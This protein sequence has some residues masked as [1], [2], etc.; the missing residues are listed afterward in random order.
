MRYFAV[1]LCAL[2]LSAAQQAPFT[3][4][5]ALSAAF[6]SELTAAPVGGMVAWV[7]NV[8]GVRNI[9]IAGPPDY[10]ARSITAYQA[11]DGQEIQ[12]LAWA[13]DASAIAYVR[14]GP[15]NPT[16]NPA[17]PSRDVWVISLN[18]G[19]PRKISDGSSPS[20]APKGNRIAYLR[21]GQ[22][23]LAPAD[24]SAPPAQAFHDSGR[25][26]K[27]VWSPDGSRFA[28]SSIRGDHSF[29]GVFDL[30]SGRVRFLNPSTANDGDP[31]WAPDGRSVAFIRIPSTG[32]R[33]PRQAM[34]TGE[35]WSIHIA[36]PETGEGREIWRAREG[37]GSVFRQVTAGSQLLWSADGRIAFPWE[38][39][40]WTHLYSVSAAG[41]D[42]ALLTPGG[43]EVE[44]VALAPGGR[45]LVFSSNQSDLDR[46][47][48]WRVAISGGAPAAVTS[49]SGIECLPAVASDGA[50][51]FMRSNARRPVHAAILIGS[52]TAREL[53][54][55]SI[56]ADFPERN[57]VEPQAVTF[58]SADGLTL[59]A[60]LFLPP[61]KTAGRAPAV[62]FFH[63]GPRRQMMLGWHPMRYYFNAYALNQ[64]LANSGYIVLSVNFRSGIG[65]GM[66]FREAEGYGAS[67][68]SDY[69]DVRAAATYLRTRADVDP[70]RVGAWG[71][72]YGGFLTAMALARNSDLFRAGVDF[73][74]VHNWATELNIPPTEPDYKIAFDSSP[75]AFV[76]TWRSPALLIHGDD[77]PDVQF[78]QTV[79]LASALR[80]QGVAVQELILPNESHEFL[81]HSSWVRTYKAAIEFLNKSLR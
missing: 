60:Q 21:S 61:S 22:I 59:H 80:K 52:S 12:N 62:V 78:N 2:S 6:P 75:M 44:D 72:S 14:G 38:G 54:P 76:K 40:G 49:G 10:R 19:Q 68:A 30:A 24:G 39:D 73:H 67:G 5:Q 29:V 69:N 13:P 33:Q 16:L 20:F 27:P 55:N 31:A 47:H 79:M 7:S 51:A 3:I 65:Y 18:G 32:L 66:E 58:Q 4:E 64:Y 57:M 50:V 74:G 48:L 1:L 28:F 42:A 77:D 17:G 34:R 41:G 56:P 46:R 53:D 8:R 45:E 71:G 25:C 81:L 37:V 63:G 9:L 43:F 23:W 15:E 70:S 36:S 35:P 26:T 11:D